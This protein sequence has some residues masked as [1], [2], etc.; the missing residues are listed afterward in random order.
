LTREKKEIF[1]LSLEGEMVPDP[2]DPF[3]PSVPSDNPVGEEIL[4]NFLLDREREIFDPE[5]G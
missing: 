3:F 4:A 2:R 1:P 5:I